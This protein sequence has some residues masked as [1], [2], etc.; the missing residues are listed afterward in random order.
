MITFF[1]VIGVI[2]IPMGII[3]LAVTNPVVQTEA[4][5][6]DNLA[7]DAANMTTVSIPI[8]HDMAPPVFF[9]YQLTNFFQNHRLYVKSRD[10]NQLRG[11]MLY[12]HDI[13]I[14]IEIVLQK[15]I[16]ESMIV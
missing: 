6:Y 9:Y 16:D 3:A 7:K 5:R 8:M 12:F 13:Y 11:S 2:L 14:T 4:V 10:S 15:R 1:V